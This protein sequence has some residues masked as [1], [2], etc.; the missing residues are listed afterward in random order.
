MLS[1]EQNR[2]VGAIFYLRIDLGPPGG[3]TQ[4]PSLRS[5][6]YIIRKVFMLFNY[7]EITVI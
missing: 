1:T 3:T 2:I 5:N 4:N 7:D 6:F